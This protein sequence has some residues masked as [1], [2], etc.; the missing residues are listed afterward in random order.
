MFACRHPGP[1]R[2]KSFVWILTSAARA[3]MNLAN[4][5][6]FKTQKLEGNVCEGPENLLS[7]N[8]EALLRSRARGSE[9]VY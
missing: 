8:H 2:T 7:K 6:I 4:V 9:Q 1:G 5:S 3:N